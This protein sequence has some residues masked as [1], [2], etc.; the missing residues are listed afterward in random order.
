MIKN[1]WT[2]NVLAKVGKS[3]EVFTEKGHVWQV[4]K[5]RV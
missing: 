1:T 2:L 3:G 5:S 4:S